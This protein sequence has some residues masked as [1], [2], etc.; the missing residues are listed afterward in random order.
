MISQW[1]NYTIAD[2]IT[3]AISDIFDIVQPYFILVHFDRVLFF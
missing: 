1:W 3:M 2:D